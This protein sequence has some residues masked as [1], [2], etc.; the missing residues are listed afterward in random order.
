MNGDFVQDQYK[1]HTMNME[2]PCT[3]LTNNNDSETSRDAIS[4]ILNQD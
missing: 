2:C 3:I 1:R 4:V